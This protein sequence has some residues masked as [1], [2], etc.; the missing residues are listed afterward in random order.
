MK[1]T[2]PIAVYHSLKLILLGLLSTVLFTSICSA[3]DF[4]YLRTNEG[5]YNGE[6]NSIAQDHSGKMWF[7]TWTGLVSYN[8]YNFEFFTPEL[9]NPYSLPDK[10]INRIFID[11]HDRLWIASLA[12]VSYFD[13][14]EIKFRTIDLEGLSP[15]DYY[16]VGFFETK[17]Q[18]IAHTT[19]GLFL[20][21]NDHL[22]HPD[23]RAQKLHVYD[24]SDEMYDYIHVAASFGEK[25][26]LMTKN[27]VQL[28]VRIMLPELET[29]NNRH[30]LQ[31]KKEFQLKEQVNNVEYSKEENKLYIATFK[32]IHVLS[33]NQ[34]TFQSQVYF[35]DINILNL[36]L[37]SDHRLY[38]YS[39]ETALLYVDLS[40]GR[41]GKY[42]PDPMKP[43]SLLD[44]NLMCLMEDFSGNLW[45]GTQ[46]QGINIRNLHKKEFYSYK[47]DPA[48]PHSLSGNTVMCINS[49]ANDV[50][51]GLRQGGLNVTPKRMNG[52]HA[53][54][55]KVI[56]Y[57][58]NEKPISPFDHIWDIAR[59]S[60]SVFWIASDAGVA[61]MIKVNNQWIYGPK[62][63]QPIY[64]GTVRKLLIDKHRNI[65]CGTF[66]D[67]LFF[68]PALRNNPERKIY[69]YPCD[70][71]NNESLTDRTVNTMMID[72]HN[73]FWIGTVN[74][75]NLVK[76]PY[77]QLDL[78]GHTKPDVRF[79]QYLGI[80][81]KKDFLKANEIN[82]IFENKDDKLWIA[83]QGGGINIMDP[84]AEH[85]THLTTREGLPGNDIQGILSDKTGMQWIS[86]FKGIVSID[87]KKNPPVFTVYGY[88]DGLQGE[89]FK[90]N[91]YHQSADGE[92]FFGGDNGFTRFYPGN[93][94]INPIAPKIGFTNLRILNRIVKVGDTIHNDNIMSRTL[95]ETESIELPYEK[96][97]FSIGV[98]IHHYQYPNGNMI[99]Y[100]L[101][102]Y[103]DNWITVPASNQYIYFSKLPDG[104]YTLHVN[105]MS[106]DN[107]E[108][109]EER[110]LHIHIL[111]PW[112]RTWYMTIIFVLMALALVGRTFYMFAKRQRLAFQKKIDAIEVENTENKMKFL[113]NIAHELRTPLSLVIAPIEEMKINY[114][115][116]EPKWKNH[117][118][119]IYRN[120]NYLLTLINQII[121]F[122]KLNAGKLQLNLQR[123]DIVALVKEVTANFKGLESRRKTNL[124]ILVPEQTILVN[125]DKQKIEEV[126]Y[127]LLSNAFKH[128]GENQSIAVSLEIVP[129]EN[130][131]T[132]PRQIRISVFNEGKDISDADKIKIFEHFYKV[133]ESVEGA[134]IGL[135]FSKSLVEMHKGTISVES[136]DGIGVEFHVM[137]PFDE[138]EVVNLNPERADLEL[139]WDDDILDHRNESEL[140]NN[141]K[142]LSIVIVEDNEDLRSFLNNSLSDT[143]NCYEAADGLEGLDL[144]NKVIPD[145]VI[146]DVVMPKMDGYELCEKIKDSYKTCH[147]PVILLTARIAEEHIVSGYEKGADAYVTKPFNMTIIKAQLSRLIKNRELIREKY[148]T[149]NFMVEVTP[150]SATSRDDEF[151]LKLRQS[152]EENLEA[153]DFNV[154][155]LSEELNISKTHLYRKIKAL[156]GL[157]PVEFILLFKMQKACELLAG[158][159]SIKAIGYSLGFKNLS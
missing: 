126:L 115:E 64:K 36:L 107:I 22:D 154:H 12:G 44:N 78:S 46:G 149:Q 112:Y 72:S 93:I 82:C 157:S 38:C 30:I 155:K 124:Q 48:N 106:T 27:N 55:F 87:M 133:N 129:A 79:K 104:K 42:V 62:N 1:S 116:I 14:K 108:A 37:T 74:G 3:D 59:E 132:S 24:S 33:L 151:I 137:L 54:E 100:K 113:T 136:V 110:I 69:Q 130:D 17:G 156:T 97:S 76:T 122:R 142:E 34:G 28:P 65:W 43:G 49:T 138:M 128:T 147:I 29:R 146:S 11:S 118:N 56:C 152:L 5:L 88:S 90:I 145:I 114:P 13:N 148:I 144:I 86:T 18:V 26:V 134:G 67:G 80:P 40:S 150:A 94:R 21:D 58:Q 25:I 103:N 19:K 63:E 4:R 61:R 102:G 101:E 53:A 85:F 52:D 140:Q 109:S 131:G 95:N 20:M 15:K 60:D 51:I 123:T 125:I 99:H 39:G 50:F 91:S 16:V 153:S 70:P 159:E 119:L 121:D 10:K 143:Y 139:S 117:I 158:N 135:S 7:A 66:F 75:L 57:N 47:R 96:N 83:T 77:D 68:F 98:G 41:T 45:I 120:S 71:A 84:D 111:P 8:G 89:T 9:D 141:G 127:N 2:K 32:G 6:I 92:M 35:D 81:H 23:F 73:R 105:A 31:I